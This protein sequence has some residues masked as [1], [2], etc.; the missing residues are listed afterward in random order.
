MNE[1]VSE[2]RLLRDGVLQE[3]LDLTTS[4]SSKKYRREDDGGYPK[5]RSNW[6]ARMEKTRKKREHAGLQVLPFKY[7]EE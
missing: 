3:R 7:R 1:K 6:W 2:I 4:L 5:S